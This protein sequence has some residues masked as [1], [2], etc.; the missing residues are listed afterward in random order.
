MSQNNNNIENNYIVSQDSVIPNQMIY[1]LYGYKTQ[2]CSYPVVYVL[3][4]YNSESHVNKRINDLHSINGAH[5][6]NTWT[7]FVKQY[8]LDDQYTENYN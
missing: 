2:S 5:V 1:I 7:Y 3:G 6:L 8:K 4:I